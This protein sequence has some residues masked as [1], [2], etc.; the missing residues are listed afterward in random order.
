[1]NVTIKLKEEQKYGVIFFWNTLTLTLT[2]TDVLL[3][4]SYDFNISLDV[5][6]SKRLVVRCDVKMDQP[7]SQAMQ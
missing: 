2:L 1:M 3:S 5:K 7:S 4:S 6:Q